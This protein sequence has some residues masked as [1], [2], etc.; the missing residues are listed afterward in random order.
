M[1][2]Y[3]AKNEFDTDCALYTS[4]SKFEP[5]HIQAGKDSVTRRL[6]LGALNTDAPKQY[7]ENSR[8]KGGG[9]SHKEL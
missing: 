8:A 4:T 1:G 3:V 7:N 9:G 5:V 6:L 2:S